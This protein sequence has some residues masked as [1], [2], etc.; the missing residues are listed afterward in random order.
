MRSFFIFSNQQKKPW[1]LFLFFMMGWTTTVLAQKSVSGTVRDHTGAPLSGASVIIKDDSAKGTLTDAAGAFTLDVPA[2]KNT[3]VISSV[4]YHTQE[5]SIADLTQ[6]NINLKPDDLNLNEV[7]VTGYTGQRKKDITGSV[8]VVDMRSIKSIPASSAMQALQGQAAGVNVI[9][10][11]VPGAASMIFVRGVSSFGDNQPL[12]IIDGIQGDINTISTDDIESMQ[13]LKDAGAASIYGVRGSN[14]VIVINTKKGKS[15]APT[16]SYHGYYGIQVPKKGNALN[17]MNSEEYAAAHKLAYPGTILFANGIPDYLYRGPGGRGTAMEGDPAVD[18]SRYVLDRQNPTNNYLIEKVNKEG[19]DWY[20]AFFVNAPMTNHTVTASGGTDKSNYLLS[21]G[22]L[23]QQGPIIETFLK[24]YTVRINTQFKLPGNI[25]IGENVALMY[26]TLSGFDNR[27]GDFGPV[28]SLYAML[29]IIPVYD[30]MGNFG[31]TFSGPAEIG[32]MGNPVA[33]QKTTNNNRRNIWD[34]V[35]NLYAEV[36]FLKR[37]TLR[38]S[39]GGPLQMAYSQ[40]FTPNTYWSPNEYNVPNRYSEGASY[41]YSTMW[42]N[43]LTYNDNFGKHNVKAFVGTE[44]I[45]SYGR[46]VSGGSRNFFA[47][48][49]DYLILGNGTTNI[50]NSSSAYTN[51]LFSIFGRVDYTYDDKYLAGF[52]LRRDGSSRF[53]S[54][55]RYG[56]FPSYSIGW[57]ISNENFM[58]RITWIDE[59]KLRGTYG[60]LGSQN[61]ISPTNAFTLFAGGIGASYYDIAGTSNSTRQ[62]FYQSNIGNP[63]IGW[64]EDIVLNGG[65]DISLFKKLSVSVELYKKTIKGLLFSQPLPATVGGASRP[66]VNIGDIQNTGVDIAIKY[67]TNIGKDLRLNSFFN[68]GTYKNLVKEIPG[69]GYF[70]GIGQQQLGTLV[71]NQEGKPVS[72]FFG[73]E[74]MGLFNT[75]EEVDKAPTQTNAAPGRFRYRDVNGDGAITPDDRTVLGSPNPDFTYSLNLGLEYK[76][77]DFAAFFYG[78]QGNELINTLK[79]NSHFFGGY[80]TNKSKDLLNAWTPTNTNTTIPVIEGVASFSTAGAMNSFFVE[81]GSYLRLKSLVLGYSF[82]QDLLRKLH[83]SKLRPYVQVTN[84]FTITNYSGL[85]PEIM[86]AAQNFGI[87]WGNY[88]NNIKN[89]VFGLEITF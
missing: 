56:T 59:I 72:A 12:I 30:I 73:Y 68:F 63:N 48:N 67:Y 41:G 80:T 70:D 52:T 74:V 4:G 65:L 23:N 58:K 5:V 79:V 22:Y 55:K 57:R 46:N 77:F 47:T 64:E 31:S 18:P 43:T 84:L 76:G 33:V 38:S 17:L 62:G 39:F 61:N 35:G 44:A 25:R 10:S 89:F 78:T 27:Q 28:Y 50:T 54:N 7:V 13:V 81:D 8:A 16:V 45:S 88:P 20:N 86:N 82:S 2:G 34:I 9:S 87:D 19:T 6:I 60:I 71:R 75:Q 40:T 15:G 3:L 42:T 85:D 66:F 21:A 26:S 1:I 14:G 37:F 36:D 69:P 29:P 51:S 11:G 49:F 53:G 24:R 32:N 83:L